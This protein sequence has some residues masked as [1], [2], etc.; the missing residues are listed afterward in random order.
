MEFEDT[1]KG[2]IFTIK[3]LLIFLGIVLFLLPH[4]RGWPNR[5]PLN[6]IRIK[7]ARISLNLLVDTISR[8]RTSC[9][10]Y[11]AILGHLRSSLDC[12][13]WAPVDFYNG[14]F[15]DPWGTPWDYQVSDSDFTI[16]SLGNDKR[17]GGTGFD[18]DLWGWPEEIVEPPP[19]R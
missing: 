8:Y 13:K 16:K 14:P 6:R 18:R 15:V 11:P 4:L 10:K 3:G 1:G 2:R 9:G 17:E 7:D 12:K 19:T 5:R